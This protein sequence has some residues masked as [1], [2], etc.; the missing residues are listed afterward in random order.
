MANEYRSAVAAEDVEFKAYSRHFEHREENE[1]EQR[2]AVIF[3][4]ATMSF[5]DSGWQ[6]EMVQVEGHVDEWILLEDPPGYGDRQRTYLIASGSSLHEVEEVPKT[7]VVRY[8]EEGN[9]TTRV[10]VVP[11][12]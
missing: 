10:S 9:E 2:R 3:V 1:E 11:W 4:V 5:P 12:D 8:G 6:V 7:I